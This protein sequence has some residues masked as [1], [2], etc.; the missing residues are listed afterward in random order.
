MSPVNRR[1]F[2][3]VV[4]VNA[5]MLGLS[6]KTLLAASP[7][8][9]QPVRPDLSNTKTKTMTERIADFIVEANFANIPPQV[10]QKAKEQV[11]Y[12]FG[13]AFSGW[14]TKESQEMREVLRPYGQPRGAT[15]I[16]ERLRLLPSDAAFANC[17][18]MRS[19]WRDD[20][21]WPAGIHA[22]LMTLPTAFAIGELKRVSGREMLAAIVLG[23]EV[24]G[25]L[26]RAANSWAAPLPR[27]PT[28]IFGSFGPVT[29]AG[30]LL[31]LNSK[32]M[33][34]ALGYATNLGMGVPEG[35]QME[36]FYGLMSRNATFAAQLA[37]LGGAP[38]S[39]STI[40]GDTGLYRSFFGELPNTLNTLISN[41][42]SGWEILGADK[43]VIRAHRKTQSPPNCFWTW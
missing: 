10:I 33:A 42:G 3:E 12:H 29:V 39:K 4:G 36:H 2:L 7:T 28:I 24:L 13:I 43:N 19:T 25:K 32:S 27:R 23:Y 18:L 15:V 38:Y 17:T 6:S 41:L 34:N 16:A 26:G 20:V 35:G 40:E 8:D 1:T 9:P 30:R 22:G 31:G 37:E 11:V 5:G 21:V 14:S